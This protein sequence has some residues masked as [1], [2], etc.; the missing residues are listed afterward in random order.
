MAYPKS[1]FSQREMTGLIREFAKKVSP[2]VAADVLELYEREVGN[3][4]DVQSYNTLLSAY[5]RR[6]DLRSVEKLFGEME[7]MTGI[8]PD[9][10]SFGILINA[11]AKAGKMSAAESALRTM[12]SYRVAPDISIFTSLMRGYLNIGKFSEVYRCEERVRRSGVPPDSVMYNVLMDA[13]SKEGNVERAKE[14]FSRMRENHVHPDVSTFTT[15]IHL[16]TEKGEYDRA[17]TTFYQ[18]RNYGLDPDRFAYCSLI[19]SFARAND[20]ELAEGAFDEMQRAQIQPDCAVYNTLLALHIRL[21]QGPESMLERMR[22]DGVKEDNVTYAILANA[23]AIQGRTEKVLDA[24]RKMPLSLHVLT[25]KMRMYAARGDVDEVLV[26]LREAKRLGPDAKVYNAAI[27]ALISVRRYGSASAL[28]EE[29]NRRNIQFDLATFSLAMMLIARDRQATRGDVSS[30]LQ[31]M[32]ENQVQPDAAIFNAMLRVKA[33]KPSEVIREMRK[34][35]VERDSHTDKALVLSFMHRG[36]V[37]RGLAAL[38][39][40]ESWSEG[41]VVRVLK[42]LR[43]LGKHAEIDNVLL[44]CSVRGLH[45]DRSSLE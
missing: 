8:Q 37:R 9:T 23:A 41:L 4:A 32:D 5:S 31:K 39:R 15:L 40:M 44:D 26:C 16:Y 11:Y 6:N 20:L 21:G 29:M 38:R 22:A 13:A 18:L 14:F 27:H 19:S 30:L 2:A 28:L 24:A 35:K 45:M 42:H 7:V 33:L 12:G 43:R 36:D 34:R 3:V 25:S 17:A 1:Q 10:F